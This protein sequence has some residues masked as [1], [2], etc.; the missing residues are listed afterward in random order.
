ME[1]TAS[2]VE[3]RV[4]ESLNHLVEEESTRKLGELNIVSDVQE[5]PTG[6]ITVRFT[7]ISP[8]SPTAVDMGRRIREAALGVQGVISATVLCE[9]HMLDDVVNKLVNKEKPGS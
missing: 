6:V 1:R 4:R 8:C 7:P 9:G 3:A 2:D 5:R